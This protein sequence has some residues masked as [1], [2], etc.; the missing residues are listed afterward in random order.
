MFVIYSNTLFI[1]SLNFLASFTLKLVEMVVIKCKNYKKKYY[2]YLHFSILVDR[3]INLL[4]N[5]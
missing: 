1:V 5:W 4:K 3:N 2:S